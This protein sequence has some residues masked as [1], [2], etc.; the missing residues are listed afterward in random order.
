MGSHIGNCSFSDSFSSL[1]FLSS[2]MN[3]AKP[4]KSCFW[5]PEF[6]LFTFSLTVFTIAFFTGNIF[7]GWVAFDGMKESTKE[8]RSQ[9]SESF[10]SLWNTEDYFADLNAQY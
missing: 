8:F 4:D 9:L 1:S 6:W 7:L 5:T 3:G 2:T 10:Q